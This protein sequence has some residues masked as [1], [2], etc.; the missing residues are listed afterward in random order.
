MRSRSKS[1][2][3]AGVPL[4]RSAAT[5]IG[6]LAVRVHQ[7]ECQAALEAIGAVIE[8]DAQ[9]PEGVRDGAI[10]GKRPGQAAVRIADA[11]R[12]AEV[13]VVQAQSPQQTRAIGGLKKRSMMELRDAFQ[14]RGAGWTRGGTRVSRL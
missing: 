6:H 1:G 10:G 9:F 13:A 14:Q 5:D 4:F 12:P 7:R 3:P 11:E 8:K 2:S